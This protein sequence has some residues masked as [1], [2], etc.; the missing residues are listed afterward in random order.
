LREWA[1]RPI[2]PPADLWGTNLTGSDLT[3]TT[4]SQTQLDKACGT[5]A[6]LDAG[7]TLKPC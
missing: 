5:K 6:K 2:S 7:L 3:G 1:F 4:V